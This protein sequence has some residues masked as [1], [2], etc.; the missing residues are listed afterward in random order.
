MKKYNGYRESLFQLSLLIEI[1][2]YTNR[3]QKKVFFGG[4]TFVAWI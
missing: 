1:G 4:E 2:T 3:K